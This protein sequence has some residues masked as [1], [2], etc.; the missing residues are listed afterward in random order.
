M[1]P[2]DS[3]LSKVV[4]P[5]QNRLKCPRRKCKALKLRL[6][7]LS[8]LRIGFTIWRN[9]RS[10]RKNLGIV[11]FRE[12]IR[13][14]FSLY[15]KLIFNRHGKVWDIGWDNNGE[16]ESKTSWLNPKSR[17]SIALVSNGSKLLSLQ[18]ST[19]S[20][21]F[22]CSRREE[23]GKGRYPNWKTSGAKEASLTRT[24]QTQRGE[25]QRGAK[26]TEIKNS[27]ALNGRFVSNPTFICGK[28]RNSFA[29]HSRW[30]IS[31]SGIESL[32]LIWR[33]LQEM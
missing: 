11:T 1:T 9:W 19:L 33:F 31:N 2:N 14:R 30:I 27:F 6:T 8:S 20:G 28:E 21:P 26:Q 12:R 16:R 15:C 24:S 29:S 22:G 4:I 23:T 10:L 32:L 18:Q 3:S 13:F 7:H 5:L 25:S 17:C